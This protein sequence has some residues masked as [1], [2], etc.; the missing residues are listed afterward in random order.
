MS[1]DIEELAKPFWLKEIN[2][3]NV[4]MCYDF[5]NQYYKTGKDLDILR[6]ILE[7]SKAL[8]YKV[9]ILSMESLFTIIS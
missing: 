6:K 5:I 2:P 7:S 8:E 9:I 4:E 3:S 1:L